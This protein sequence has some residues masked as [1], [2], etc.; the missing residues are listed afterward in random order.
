MPVKPGGQWWRYVPNP[1][2]STNDLAIP[3]PAPGNWAKI[4]RDC[5]WE[6]SR[7]LVVTPTQL[8]FFLSSQTQNR[9]PVL[10]QGRAKGHC[11]GDQDGTTFALTVGKKKANVEALLG[12][13]IGEFRGCILICTPDNEVLACTNCHWNDKGTRCSLSSARQTQNKPPKHG[14]GGQGDG[15]GAED[16]QGIVDFVKGWLPRLEQKLAKARRGSAKQRVKVPRYEKKI[17]L[18]KLTLSRKPNEATE[19]PNKGSE[20][21]VRAGS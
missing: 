20:E 17:E 21:G 18:A 4:A 19:D 7:R 1:T 5:L 11:H 12:H 16:G 9:E 14:E 10:M 3:D 13:S 2:S 15:I 6:C 8:L